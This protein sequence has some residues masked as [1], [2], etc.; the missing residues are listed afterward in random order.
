M[1]DYRPDWIGAVGAGIAALISFA[2]AKGLV[3]GGIEVGVQ[4]DLPRARSRF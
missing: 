2:I 3:K 4:P 1:N